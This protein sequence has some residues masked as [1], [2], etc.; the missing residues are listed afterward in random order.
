MHSNTV[1]N[2]L[3]NQSI[4]EFDIVCRFDFSASV[5]ER[6]GV[7]GGGRKRIEG[8]EGEGG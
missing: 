6:L 4:F 7:E 2:T 8:I 1:S 3:A 5:T